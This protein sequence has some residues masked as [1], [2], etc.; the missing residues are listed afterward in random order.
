MP[1]TQCFAQIGITSVLK[2]DTFIELCRFDNEEKT[3]DREG[4]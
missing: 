1:L 2:S 3:G 4:G